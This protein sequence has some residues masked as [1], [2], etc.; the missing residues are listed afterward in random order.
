ME[1]RRIVKPIR[2][3]PRSVEANDA[4]LA[5]AIALV[6]EVG[7]DNVTIEAIAGRAGVGKATIYRRWPSKEPLI[8]DAIGGIVSVI[9][10][11]LSA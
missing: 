9:S 8:A 10:D 1:R 2:G 4:I 6:R 3:R 7:Y 11:F 5:A